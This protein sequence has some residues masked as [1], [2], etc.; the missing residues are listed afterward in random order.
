MS[1]PNHLVWPDSTPEQYWQSRR[2]A[3]LEWLPHATREAVEA[4]AMRHFD[5][6]EGAAYLVAEQI[7]RDRLK[8]QR[9]A[10]LAVSAAIDWSAQSRRPS[11]SELVRRR[12]VVT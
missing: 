10:S 9:E 11:W 6:A 12:S 3:V 7:E 4:F 1:T 8:A 2:N 5:R